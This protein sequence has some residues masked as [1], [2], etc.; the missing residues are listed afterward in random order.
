MLYAFG[1]QSDLPIPR[2]AVLNTDRDARDL[3]PDSPEIPALR[4]YLSVV[5]PRHT[6][7]VIDETYRD[8][9]TLEKTKRAAR[10]IFPGT[11]VIGRTALGNVIDSTPSWYWNETSDEKLGFT[12][13]RLPGFENDLD[14]PKY[15][16]VA[17]LSAGNPADHTRIAEIEEFHHSLATIANATRNCTAQLGAYRESPSSALRLL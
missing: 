6:I 12:T 16:T 5:D 2:L 13:A 3:T 14:S 4:A 15:R 17:K 10:T 7:A 11:R 8:G 1:R 9:G